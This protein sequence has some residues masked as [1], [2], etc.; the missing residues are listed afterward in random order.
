MSEASPR[1]TAG[2]SL[3]SHLELKIFAFPVAN[4]KVSLLSGALLGL[5]FLLCCTGCGPSL[6]TGKSETHA[7]EAIGLLVLRKG[8]TE[9]SSDALTLKEKLNRSC[10]P[11]SLSSATVTAGLDSAPAE[12]KTLYTQ[13]EERKS[14]HRPWTQNVLFSNVGWARYCRADI[15][16]E[17]ETEAC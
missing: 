3:P 17:E 12:S 14:E 10:P 15:S 8:W 6:A 1:V 2:D 16:P 4:D 11:L 13:K 5:F 7:Q 9:S